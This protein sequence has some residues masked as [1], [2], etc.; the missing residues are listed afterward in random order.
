MAATERHR[1]STGAV[2]LC[3]AWRLLRAGASRTT[4][5]GARV[6]ADTSHG[7]RAR[8]SKAGAPSINGHSRPRASGRV[9]PT[10]AG[11][12]SIA[13]GRTAWRAIASRINDGAST[14]ALRRPLHTRLPGGSASR[15]GALLA[16]GKG[17]VL[18]RRPSF[19]PPISRGPTRTVHASDPGES[20]AV[21]SRRL[22][23]GAVRAARHI[24]PSPCG[25]RSAASIASRPISGPPAPVVVACAVDERPRLDRAAV[26]R[27][28][29]R[30]RWSPRPMRPAP[31]GRN[32]PPA[33]SPGARP[34]PG[35]ACAST[36]AI[37]AY[38]S[39]VSVQLA[40]G[41]SR[42]ASKP[43]ETS[44][45]S[46]GVR[47]RDRRDDVL[48]QAEPFGVAGPGRH[49][50]VDRVPLARA[51]AAVRSTRPSPDTAG[52]GGC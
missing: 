19:C 9:R 16:G 26:A 20:G 25:A 8:A 10:G 46:G 47:A 51:G 32:H 13:S 18:A 48:D 5:R 52:T 40:S 33:R 22:K 1:R 15:W 17:A 44:T 31:P 24:L 6:A 36:P 28:P 43:A 29:A 41:S 21:L 3:R 39:S 35:R 4:P 34:G 37:A 27:R 11:G 12:S 50:Q 42:W 14:V 2:G 23:S 30:P 38:D 45:R 49:R 7:R